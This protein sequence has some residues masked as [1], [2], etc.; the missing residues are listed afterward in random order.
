MN[1]FGTRYVVSIAFCVAAAFAM[2]SPAVA[3]VKKSPVIAVINYAA[4]LRESAAGKSLR[5]QVEKQRAIYQTEI[6]SI[7]TKLEE[8]RAELKKQQQVLAPEVFAKKRKEVLQQTEQ[9]Q[10]AAQNRKRQL[11]RMQAKG[12]QEIDKA[13]RQVLEEMA[14]EEGYDLILNAGPRGSGIV[15]AGK[16]FFITEEAVKRL[17]AKL[18]TVT[19][20]PSTE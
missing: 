2:L 14:K 7:Q 13:L 8:A 17:N 12:I 10:R 20:T 16:D 5:G 4:A 18:P 9:L 6:K 19:V 1:N 15:M 11:D 3:Q